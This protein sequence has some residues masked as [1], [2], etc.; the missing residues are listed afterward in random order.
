M[1]MWSE[2]R[3]IRTAG[4]Q[5]YGLNVTMHEQLAC[6]CVVFISQYTNS[7]HAVVRSER[8]NAR[9]AGMQLYGLNV[10]MREQLACKCV[11]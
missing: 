7:W 1:Q 6:K 11:V 9:T 3:N 10:T 8:R 4:M 5:S 2:Y